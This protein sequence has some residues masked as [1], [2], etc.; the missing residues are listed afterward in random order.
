MK[1]LDCRAGDNIRQ[2]ERENGLVKPF[3]SVK[4]N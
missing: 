1:E 4:L 3:A 2:R